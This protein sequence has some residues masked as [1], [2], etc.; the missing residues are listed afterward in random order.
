MAIRVLL[1]EDNEIIRRV[2]ADLL[3]S[4]PGI[5]VIAECA[6]FA[7]ALSLASATHPEVVLL[8]CS[9][10]RRAHRHILATKSRHGGF[11]I[12]RDVNLERRRN[13]GSC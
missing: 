1:A 13:K 5:E 4:D 2:I 9:H 6:G 3:K 11:T 8:D 7:E 10:G 12:A